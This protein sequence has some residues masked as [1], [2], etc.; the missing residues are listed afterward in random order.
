MLKYS[1]IEN[2][3]T[4]EQDDFMAHVTDVR[5]YSIDE[6]IERMLKRG[7]LLTKADISAV[8]EVYHDVIADII[9]DG[10]AIHTPLINTMPSIPGVFK[11]AEDSFDVNRHQTKV[12]VNPGKLLREAATK[13][14]VTKVHI[15]DPAPYILEVK[16]ILSGKVNEVLTNGGVVQL[17]GG[18]LKFYNDKPE[19]GVF[20]IDEN[21]KEIRCEVI[22]ENKPARIIA[23][24]PA[25]IP[26][27]V[28][29][30]EVRTSYSA[31]LKESKT[32]KTGQ[33]H[34]HLTLI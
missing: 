19:N 5:S 34:K 11:G 12:N 16:D 4:P 6:I 22:V 1:L 26:K 21:K 24:I 15:D 17:S 31:S 3:L 13:I 10:G 32:L 28:Y 18:R 7:T 9:E 8:L 2:L 25:G 30:L 14:K 23:V 20:L 33:F 29:K 27:T